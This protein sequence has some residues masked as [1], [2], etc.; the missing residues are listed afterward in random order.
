MFSLSKGIKI[1]PSNG[2]SNAIYWNESGK[3]IV[4]GDMRW[5]DNCQ[6]NFDVGQDYT[7]PQ[8]YNANNVHTELFG[9]ATVDTADFEIF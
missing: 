5:Q 7:M 1:L 2:G 8:G 9:G 4:W 6:V 3:I